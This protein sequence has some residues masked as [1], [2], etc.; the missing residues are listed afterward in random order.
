MKLI[1]LLL[2]KYSID[3]QMGCFSKSI[4]AKVKWKWMKIKNK[5]LGHVLN[6][7]YTNYANCTT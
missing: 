1:N 6:R 7:S 4:S 3:L 5:K 2:H